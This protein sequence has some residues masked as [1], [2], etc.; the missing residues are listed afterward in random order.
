M[1]VGLTGG[2]GSGKSVIA[3]QLREMGF[4]VYD[5]DSEAKRLIIEDTSVRKQME[6]LFG[7]EVYTDGVYQTALE[8][9]TTITGSANA[10]KA[11]WANFLVGLADE[12][13]D[14]E[15]LMDNLVTSVTTYLGNLIPRIKIL[16][17]RLIR[18]IS[19]I[20]THVGA[21][22]PSLIGEIAPALVTGGISLIKS[23]I[24]SLIGSIPMLKRA[25]I[26]VIKALYEGFTGK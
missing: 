20:A 10:M 6:E 5:T 8:A 16:A 3:K 21:E 14:F 13:A 24:T 25:A 9:S 4:A 19:E 11:A 22:L 26:E 7:K 1:I 15:T 2:I 23:L 12:E 17:P 18:G